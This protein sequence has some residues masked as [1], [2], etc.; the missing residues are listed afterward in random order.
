MGPLCFDQLLL[1]FDPSFEHL[2]FWQ[3]LA[4]L[5]FAQSVLYLLHLICTVSQSLIT[6]L[7]TLVPLSSFPLTSRPCIDHQIPGLPTCTS[8]GSNANTLN[9]TFLLNSTPMAPAQQSQS[10]VGKA[11]ELIH[12][13]IVGV[14]SGNINA[15]RT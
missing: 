2:L 11:S 14:K 8:I 9:V 4:S 10:T 1:V 5:L 15:I 3:R 13:R 6:I 7:I 12:G